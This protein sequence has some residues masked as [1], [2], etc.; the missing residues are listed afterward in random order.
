[1]TIF[2]T[3][4]IS[5][6]L[7][8]SAFTATAQNVTITKGGQSKPVMK[9]GSEA[10]NFSAG[11]NSYFI[12]SVFESAVMKYYVE[13]F[14]A[15]GATIAQNELTVSPGVFNNS[16]GIDEVVALGGKAYA[17]VE[18]LDKPAGKNSL[19]AR[20]I[21][22]TGEVSKNETELM[23]MAFEKTMNSGYNFS[24]TSE[25]QNTLAVVGLLPYEKEVSAKL[26]IALFDKDLNKKGEYAVS[27]PGEDTKNKGL[28]IAV[29]NDGTVYIIKQTY[30]KNGEMALTVYQNSGSTE[31]KEY[32][33]EMT[34]PNYFTTYAYTVNPAGELIISGTYYERKTVSTGDRK[35]SGI[36]YFT[37]KGKSEK[38]FKTFTLDTPVENLTARKILVNGNTIFLTAEQYK[39]EKITPPASAA[40]AASFD[41][42]YN[43]T[44]KN[45]YVIAVD[46][47]GN[48]KFELNMAR[49]FMVRDFDKQYY[50][51]YFITNGKL[52]V[53]YNDQ[54]RKYTE[55]SGYN[56]VVPVL[57][58]ITNDGLMQS[59]VVFIDK[60][61]LSD[62][63][64]MYPISSVQ[65]SS[66]EI[67]ML[68]KNGEFSQYVNLKID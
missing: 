37:N 63:Y 9:K 18:H 27:F 57:V 23:S 46:A 16:Y 58:Q 13:A 53:I 20:E 67:S 64:M 31:L 3:T 5:F 12:T 32:T 60:L 30:I 29:G 15:S 62:Y 68:M 44:H 42:N 39:E 51:A 61:K 38:V 41:Y 25:D 19:T 11:G 43:Y 28:K 36:F 7:L 35:A 56:S 66:N 45:E 34:A 21:S 55:N 40:G 48:K 47:E 24:V 54:T 17:L 4:G 26:K 50:S 65:K 14:N 1:M 52:T 22:N 49:D 6:C 8:L 10:I 59:P 33:F 2:K